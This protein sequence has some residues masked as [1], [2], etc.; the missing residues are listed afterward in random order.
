MELMNK[1]VKELDFNNTIDGWQLH[2][3][4][5]MLALASRSF[6][7]NEYT[8][9]QTFEVQNAKNSGSDKYMDMSQ[10]GNTKAKSTPSNR[11]KE[12][13]MCCEILSLAHAFKETNKRKFDN[14]TFWDMLS[15]TTTKLGKGK[16]EKTSDDDTEVLSKLATSIFDDNK[17]TDTEYTVDH[18]LL[19]DKVM[20]ALNGENAEQNDN[21]DDDDSSIA[22][23]SIEETEEVAIDVNNGIGAKTKNIKKVKVHESATVDI[24][25]K[26]IEKMKSKN[27]PAVRYRK[28]CRLRR[29]QAALRDC[30]Y[31]NMIDTN[32]NN[33]FR[34][35]VEQINNPDDGNIF[36]SWDKEIRNLM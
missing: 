29:E 6:V 31:K 8:N 27:L 15:S 4:N 20:S 30:I 32:D 3:Q 21:N 36:G 22:P 10:K 14:S 19:D 24:L 33:L 2:S 1:N 26:G 25:T 18:S 34:V 12:K 7:M 16:K 17:N 35:T 28:N 9:H 11:S 13:V 23:E 5:V